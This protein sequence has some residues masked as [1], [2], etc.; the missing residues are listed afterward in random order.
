[1]CESESFQSC[2]ASV[3]EVDQA[4]KLNEERS[5]K[6]S[7]WFKDVASWKRCLWVRNISRGVGNVSSEL[8]TQDDF[9]DVQCISRNLKET[10]TVIIYNI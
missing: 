7:G 5:K 8:E 3:G 4:V 1:M 9:L 6:W 10:G 2:T